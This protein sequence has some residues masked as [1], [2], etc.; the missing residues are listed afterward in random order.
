MISKEITFSKRAF[1]KKLLFLQ[2]FVLILL[3]NTC[4]ID[5]AHNLSIMTFNIRYGLAD[6]GI[7]KWE[8]R[9]ELLFQTLKKYDADLIGLQE[10]LQ[11]QI[12]E[13]K[14]ALPQY[15][16][17]GVGRDDGQAAGEFSAILYKKAVFSMDTSGTFWFSSTPEISG[18][19]DWGN[20]YPRICTWGRFKIQKGGKYLYLYN[21]HLDHISQP[22]REKSVAFLSQR[23]KQRLFM[24]PVFV[25]GDFNAAENNPAIRF[26][27]SETALD[28]DGQIVK[29]PLLL[30]DS[31]RLTTA[32]KDSVGTFHGFRGFRNGDKIDYVFVQPG[33]KVNSAKIIHDHLGDIFP[34]DH[35]PVIANVSLGKN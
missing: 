11:F 1:F 10:A 5:K 31:F 15:E 27:K 8:F 2:I 29:N 22:S 4:K 25:T 13:I 18:S 32:E 19:M 3:I 12:D 28:L 24:N 20:T 6:D 30:M 17:I 21:V 23:I 33:I 34:S 35:Y 14:Q 9:R 26:L 7:N 16:A